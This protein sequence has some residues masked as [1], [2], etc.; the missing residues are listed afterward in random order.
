MKHRVTSLAR[1]DARDELAAIYLTCDHDFSE[2]LY[3]AEAGD[4]PPEGGRYVIY[5]AGELL[6]SMHHIEGVYI[7]G[8]VLWKLYAWRGA[9]AVLGTAFSLKRLKARFF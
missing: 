2:R 6:K 7:D 3:H 4:D 9:T 8:S 5:H 1:Y